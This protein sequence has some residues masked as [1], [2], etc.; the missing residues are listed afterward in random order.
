[1]VDHVFCAGKLVARNGQM[2]EPVRPS[3]VTKPGRNIR[4]S[5]LTFDDCRIAL[6]GRQRVRL[7]TIKGA[8]FATWSEVEVNIVDGYVELPPHYGVML[9]RHRH[10]RHAAPVQK[11]VLE[12]WGDLRGAVATTYSH[13]SHNLVV[14][15][16]KPED[17]QAAA[18]AVIDAGGGMAVARDGKVTAIV[19]FPIAGLLSEAP[20]SQLA[21]AYR[22]VREAAGKVIE[23]K[24]PYRTFK[25]LEGTALAC[26]SGPHLTDLGLTDGTTGQVL[27]LLIGV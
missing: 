22:A 14:I 26:N 7:R 3:P 23:W 21:H 16:R 15:G 13:D 6:P 27:D 8:R 12:D 18:N 24:L 11:A 2:L 4:L 5:P 1:M 19:E 17:L 20:P 25:A 10:G 9:V